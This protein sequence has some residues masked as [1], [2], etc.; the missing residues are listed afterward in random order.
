MGSIHIQR[1]VWKFQA[2]TK[3]LKFP[4]KLRKLSFITSSTKETCWER[5]IQISIF[6]P[7]VLCSSTTAA[8]HSHPQL[9]CLFGSH[10]LDI[11]LRLLLPQL[12]AVCRT[13]PQVP[14][15]TRALWVQCSWDT[16]VGWKELCI[17]QGGT[18]LFQGPLFRVRMEPQA[19]VYLCWSHCFCLFF[20]LLLRKWENSCL[21]H[22][23]D[24]RSAAVA[25]EEE[26]YPSDK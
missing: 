25:G 15:Y 2:Y 9:T 22:S 26:A 14:K 3:A 19:R 6:Y 1:L 18:W 8:K 20:V 17:G 5:I 10:C 12:S 16:G 21:C 13:H 24:W 11:C 4:W 23:N 7:S